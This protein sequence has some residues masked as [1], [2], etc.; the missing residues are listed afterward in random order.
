MSPA[1]NTDPANNVTLL[2]QHLDVLKETFTDVS[3]ASPAGWS[4]ARIFNVLLAQS[5]KILTGDPVTSAIGSVKQDP[6]HPHLALT[7]NATIRVLAAIL[8]GA[9]EDRQRNT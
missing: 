3:L 1:T 8:S 2:I 7:D 5:K 6:E 4:T 9:L